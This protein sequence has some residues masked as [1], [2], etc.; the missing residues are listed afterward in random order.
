MKS[1]FLTLSLFLAVTVLPHSVSARPDPLISNQPMRFNLVE[2]R[3]AKKI[4][5]EL[6]G[7]LAKQDRSLRWIAAIGRITNETP[8]DFENFLK[9]LCIEHNI[10][11]LDDASLNTVMLSSQGGNLAA[12]VELGRLFRSKR[13]NTAVAAASTDY[14]A[15]EHVGG[16]YSAC[17]YAFVGGVNRRI[18]N[19]LVHDRPS[20]NMTGVIAAHR[21]SADGNNSGAQITSTLK[22][23]PRKIFLECSSTLSVTDKIQ[24]VDSILVAYL[25]DMG[26]HQ[27]FF[28]MAAASGALRRVSLADLKSWNV[29][30]KPNLNYWEPISWMKNQFAVRARAR[31]SDEP[32]TSI[33]IICEIGEN[34]IRVDLDLENYDRPVDDIKTYGLL[35]AVNEERYVAQNLHVMMHENRTI[36]S[37]DVPF[38]L[39]SNNS[40]T[41]EISVLSLAEIENLHNDNVI[42]KASANKKSKAIIQNTLNMCN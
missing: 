20:M 34:E 30:T 3:L 26:I 25:S 38:S 7:R 29:I 2:S 37:A 22:E 1:V 28:T 21:W 42:L 17:A 14:I 5:E 27:E 10:C 40:A 23:D 36:V 9:K 16:C 32:G 35:I 8:S 12:G 33:K 41:I 18:A 24:C 4:P 31:N 11:D 19:Y 39:L 15:Y 6:V 13:F